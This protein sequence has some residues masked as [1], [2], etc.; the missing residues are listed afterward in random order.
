MRINDAEN[1][2]EKRE[3]FFADEEEGEDQ[4]DESRARH[5]SE[6]SSVKGKGKL[7]WSAEEDALLTELY[8]RATS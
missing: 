8:N 6:Q 4:M 2:D 5:S 7:R 3:D 1:T